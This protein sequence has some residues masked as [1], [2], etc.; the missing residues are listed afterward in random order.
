MQVYPPGQA[1]GQAYGRSVPAIAAHPNLAAPPN[2]IRSRWGPRSHPDRRRRRNMIRGERARSSWWSAGPIPR[3]RDRSSGRCCWP[4]TIQRAGWSM[5]AAP[6]PASIMRSSGGCGAACSR[7]SMPNMPLNVPSPRTSRFGSPL[8]LSRVHWVRPELVIEVK[9]LTW[10]EDNL[11]RQVVYEG[12][13][14]D[15]PAAEVHRPVPHPCAR[16]PDSLNK[17][18]QLNATK[19]SPFTLVSNRTERSRVLGGNGTTNSVIG[20]RNCRCTFL[21]IEQLSSRNTVAHEP[22]H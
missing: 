19:A 21:T 2:Q 9:Y 10:T 8:V 7:L 13:R 1:P 22:V 4:I 15:K 11:L 5:R 17:T 14:E 20:A 18:A 16:A 6:V 3:A 12:L